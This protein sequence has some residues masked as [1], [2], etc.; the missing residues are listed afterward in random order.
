MF[1]PGLHSRDLFL[2]LQHQEKKMYRLRALPVALA[3]AACESA[4]ET[5]EVDPQAQDCMALA[6]YW[7]ARGEGREGMVAVGSVVM[8]RMEDERFPDD[9]CSVIRQGGETAPCQFSWW[10]DGRSDRP[11]PGALWSESREVA[12]ELLSEQVKDPTNGAIYFHHESIDPPWEK[13]RTRSIGSH[14]FY[15]D[16][17]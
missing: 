13:E 3:L 12:R 1:Y 17:P 11:K 2:T 4:T 9:V 15:R 14:I 6:M 7:E 8:N 16:P 10:C 5:A